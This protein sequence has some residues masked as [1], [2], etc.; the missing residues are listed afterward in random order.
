MRILKNIVICAIP[1]FCVLALFLKLNGI[2]HVEFTDDYYKFMSS[3][4][5]NSAKFTMEIPNIPPIPELGNGF[6][7]LLAGFIN[8]LIGIINILSM[9]INVVIKMLGFILGTF[10]SI[11]NG[12]KRYFLGELLVLRP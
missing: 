4:I 5:Q 11:I 9:M 7:D 12:I 8:G 6:L 2:D 10:E 1:I 3:V